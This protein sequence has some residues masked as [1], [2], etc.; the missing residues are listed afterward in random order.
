MS[1]DGTE[2]QGKSKCD[3]TIK[4]TNTQETRMMCKKED[5]GND[6]ALARKEQWHEDVCRGEYTTKKN[7]GKEEQGRTNI[8]EQQECQDATNVI[9]VIEN[10]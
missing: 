10:T 6:I 1:G 4:K 8:Q 9:I 5:Q 3:N 2:K 7:N